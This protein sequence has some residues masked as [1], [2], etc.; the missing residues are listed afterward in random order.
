M[1]TASFQEKIP[2]PDSEVSAAPSAAQEFGPIAPAIDGT[3]R[4][5]LVRAED[6]LPSS[7]VP[8]AKPPEI[9]TARRQQQTLALFRG[10]LRWTLL[11]MDR[12]AAEQTS[13]LFR[14]CPCHGGAVSYLSPPLHVAP[15]FSDRYGVVRCNAIVPRRTACANQEPKQT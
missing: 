13:L 11:S 15:R 8:V 12:A 7:E 14:S 10:F 3:Y 1:H 9:S 6:E 4:R 2:K 5:H